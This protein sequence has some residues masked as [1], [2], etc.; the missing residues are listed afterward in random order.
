[1]CHL[2]TTDSPI[3]NRFHRLHEEKGFISEQDLQDLAQ[4]T[5]R[6]LA[7]LHGLL[8]FF[9]S[10]R[11]SPPGKNRL[12]ICY[13]TPCYARGAEQIYQR[14]AAELEL[15]E[16]GTSTDGFITIEKVQCV[17]ACSLAPVIVTN[18][19]LE[20]RVKAHR[21]PALLNRLRDET[22]KKQEEE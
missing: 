7:D 5:G 3:I 19:Q 9:H 20:G 12:A 21:L 14:L 2:S 16:D 13:G 10:L 15:D 1:M 4:Q 22:L 6:P 11:T 17:G 8:S 18:D